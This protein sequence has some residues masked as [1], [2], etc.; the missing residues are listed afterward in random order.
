MKK[1]VLAPALA[2][3]LMMGQINPSL[4]ADD[5]GA[6]EVAVEGLT[7]L[8]DALKL[9]VDAIPQYEAPEIL[10]NGDIIIRKKNK[11]KDDE[12]EKDPKTEETAA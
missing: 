8:M 7:R 1:R 11:D 9:F 2:A 5:K 3:L 12:D 10:E 4:A 6:G